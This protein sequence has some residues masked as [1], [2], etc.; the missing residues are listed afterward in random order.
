[1]KLF[2][3]TLNLHVKLLLSSLGDSAPFGPICVAGICLLVFEA[4]KM[5]RDPR[6]ALMITGIRPERVILLPEGRIGSWQ[7]L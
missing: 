4:G 2:W 1:M 5:K 6:G 3:Q 7:F